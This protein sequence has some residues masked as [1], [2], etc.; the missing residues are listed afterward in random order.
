MAFVKLFFWINATSLDIRTVGRFFAQD[1]TKHKTIIRKLYTAVMAMKIAGILTRT[2][3]ISEVYSNAPLESDRDAS[4]LTVG[5][6]L[7]TPEEIVRIQ[8]FQLR[9]KLLE[10]HE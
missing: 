1:K 8:R 10:A 3:G 4:Q 9:R 7:N 5:T 2:A 6:M